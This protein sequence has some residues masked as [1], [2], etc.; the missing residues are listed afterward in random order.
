MSVEEI[1]FIDWTTKHGKN[2]R[3][4]EEWKFRFG[5]FKRS[6]NEIAKHD[7]EYHGSTVGLNDF[8]DLTKEEFKQMLGYRKVDRAALEEHGPKTEQ[9]AKESDPNLEIKKSVDWR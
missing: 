2:Y 4:R 1:A 9:M 6:L 3:T 5:E 7:E 8:S